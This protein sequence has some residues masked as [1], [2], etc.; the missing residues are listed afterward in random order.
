MLDKNFG[1]NILNYKQQILEDLKSVMA[2][3]SVAELNLDSQTEPLGSKAVEAL[4]F[5]LD[6]A[7]KLGLKTKNVDNIVGHAEYG[8]GEEIVAVATHLDIVPAG[9]GWDQD[10][11]DLVESN[12]SYYGRGV[13]DDKGPAIITLYCLKALMDAGVVSN[14]KIRAIFGTGEE[15]NSDDLNHYFSK[16]E[17]PSMAFTPDAEYGICNAEKGILRVS[18]TDDRNERGIIEEFIGGTVVNSVPNRAVARLRCNESEYQKLLEVA[19][20]LDCEFNFDYKYE[21]LTIEAIGIPSHAMKPENGKNAISYLVRLIYLSISSAKLGTLVNFLNDFVRL[22]TDG[23][24][25]KIDCQDEHSGALTLNLGL[26]KID[27]EGTS[28]SIDIRIPATFDKRKISD[29]IYRQALRYDLK[30]KEDCYTPALYLPLDTPIVGILRNAYKNICDEEA[31]I[32]YTGGGTYAREL[33]GRGIAFGPSFTGKNK[34]HEVGEFMS[35]DDFWKHAQIC[36]QAM[37]EMFLY[38]SE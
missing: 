6:R 3:E 19:E 11:Y 1:K 12:G 15:V 22:T 14:K 5:V 25:F 9:D 28:A 13:I 8:N 7:E 26:I 29:K 37:Y 4:N 24:L 18:I 2:I 21:D 17:L 10:P 20:T 30:F 16:E 31:R 32:Y 35:V 36:L 33:Q 27:K 38:K 34:L 23:S